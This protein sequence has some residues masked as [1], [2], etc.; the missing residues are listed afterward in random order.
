M[1]KRISSVLAM[2]VLLSNSSCSS[3]H[4]I[5]D[6]LGAF[7]GTSEV[8]LK[9]RFTAPPDANQQLLIGQDMEYRYW[10]P[11]SSVFYVCLDQSA[12]SL[13]YDRV[14]DQ[15]KDPV[16]GHYGLTFADT[17]TFAG[18]DSSGY[19]NE[20]ILFQGNV[21]YGYRGVPDARHAQL[22]QYLNQVAVKTR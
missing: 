6:S 10:F 18:L 22:E 15:F 5:A 7:D 8:R 19:W 20:T 9:V 2:V 13:N 17:V 12:V 14:Q 1:I 4:R 16:L 11:D 3:S 21:R